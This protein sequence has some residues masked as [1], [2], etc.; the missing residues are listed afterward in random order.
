[1][2][3]FI[4]CAK[5]VLQLIRERS[6]EWF[7]GQGNKSTNWDHVRYARI[8]NK[9]MW[10]TGSLIQITTLSAFN[11]GQYIYYSVFS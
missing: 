8:P 5:Y 7:F 3:P 9:F 4:K 10:L 2:V 11:I 1:M 6:N